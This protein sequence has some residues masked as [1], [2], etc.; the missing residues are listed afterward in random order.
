[1]RNSQSSADNVR[2]KATFMITYYFDKPRY[3]LCHVPFVSKE[4]RY[5][6]C[7]KP[8][9]PMYTRNYGCFLERPVDYN[10]RALE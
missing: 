1:M 10:E 2:G 4:C 8:K 9:E 7:Y 5:D 3:N 6:L